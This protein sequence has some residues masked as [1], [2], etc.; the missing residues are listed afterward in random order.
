MCPNCGAIKEDI[1]LSDRT[2]I[3]DSCGYTEDR[4]IKAAKILLLAGRHEMSCTHAE[5]MGTPEEWISDFDTS[6]EIWKHSAKR[7]EMGKR[8]EAPSSSVR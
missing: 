4:D 5:H 2:F 3:C 1:M 7:P 8:P 6:Y